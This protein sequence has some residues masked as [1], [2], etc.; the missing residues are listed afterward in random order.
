[1]SSVGMGSFRRRIKGGLAGS[2]LGSMSSRWSLHS[3]DGLAD[4]ILNEN[5]IRLDPLVKKNK[6]MNDTI[7][8]GIDAV[9]YRSRSYS[10]SL[11]RRRGS[12]LLNEPHY[13]QVGGWGRRSDSPGRWS[14]ATS[15]VRSLSPWRNSPG[16]GRRHR[17]P[18]GGRHYHRNHR[19]SDGDV[20]KD[21][22]P[23]DYIVARKHRHSEGDVLSKY[24]EDLK[25]EE[26]TPERSRKRCISEGDVDVTDP[27]KSDGSPKIEQRTE[28]KNS[29]L[30]DD[31]N[32]YVET[33]ISSVR[34]NSIT[35]KYRKEILIRNGFN[36]GSRGGFIPDHRNGIG[37]TAEHRYRNS[38]CGS[39]GSLDSI[40][41]WTSC[42]SIEDIDEH[43]EEK[44]NKSNDLDISGNTDQS[45]LTPETEHDM[46]KNSLVIEHDLNQKMTSEAGPSIITIPEFDAHLENGRI[47]Q[48]FETA[49]WI[50]QSYWN[51]DMLRS[52]ARYRR[53]L[54]IRNSRRQRLRDIRRRS[55]GDCDRRF[56]NDF[57]NGYVPRENH[58]SQLDDTASLAELAEEKEKSTDTLESCGTC[59]KGS[60]KCILE[61]LDRESELGHNTNETEH[62]H[63]QNSNDTESSEAEFVCLLKDQVSFCS[64][65]HGNTENG[66]DDVELVFDAINKEAKKPEN[67]EKDLMVVFFVGKD[68]CLK[69]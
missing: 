46:T 36:A 56:E 44:V 26:S 63:D 33:I 59:S 43:G 50:D 7:D 42:D 68:A 24:V 5:G 16:S 67:A 25:Q 39:F 13:L 58:V 51:W 29:I 54:S 4:F 41:S 8:S 23:F 38:Y 20:L 31:E 12:G 1:M 15:G 6:D 28:S 2:F 14:Q 49:S 64:G 52:D 61:Y 62:E 48:T 65:K 19:H 9:A 10:E 32:E 11:P 47:D 18:S 22:K 34:R 27:S 17:R 53:S 40:D 69:V 57:Y 45:E 55:Y 66:H 35:D 21:L 3:K 37:R 60:K 30:A